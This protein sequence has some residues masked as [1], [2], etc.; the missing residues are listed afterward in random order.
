MIGSERYLSRRTWIRLVDEVRL[1]SLFNL[2]S[3]MS[4]RLKSSIGITISINSPK[5]QYLNASTELDQTSSKHP[6]NPVFIFHIY[7]IC[8]AM[9]NIV[10]KSW[11]EERG[12]LVSSHGTKMTCHIFNGPSCKILP[13][14]FH[15]CLT[16][17]E[18]PLNS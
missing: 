13:R 1:I 9:Q 12:S 6:A 4:T 17:R 16:F 15:H 7:D 11:V 3:Y 5:C 10:N 8:S 2:S 18:I 14:T